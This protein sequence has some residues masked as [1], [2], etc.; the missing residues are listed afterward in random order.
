[1]T[2]SRGTELYSSYHRGA[3]LQLI[4]HFPSR[5]EQGRRNGQEDGREPRE[6]K[7]LTKN[8]DCGGTPQ[9]FA[10]SGHKVAGELPVII[11][12]LDWR[13]VEFIVCT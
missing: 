10:R 3:T 8:L 6:Q 11:V 5:A 4:G 13:E 2:V 9:D 7:T 12:D 1:M